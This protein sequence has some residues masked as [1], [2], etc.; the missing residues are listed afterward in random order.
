MKEILQDKDAVITLVLTIMIGLPA[1]YFATVIFFKVVKGDVQKNIITVFESMEESRE[2]RDEIQRG[3]ESQ[4]Y[5][6]NS[7]QLDLLKENLE[8]S[9]QQSKSSNLLTK[10]LEKAFSETNTLLNMHIEDLKTV[11][12]ETE[13]LKSAIENHT[14]RITKLEPK[15]I[16]S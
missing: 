5:K 10:K 12:E 6:I 4:R 9:K 13:N 3:I 15:K 7:E 8:L 16:V 1:L 14:K 2:K 11:K